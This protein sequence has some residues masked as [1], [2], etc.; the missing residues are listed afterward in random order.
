MR[1][2]A[3]GGV[4]TVIGPKHVSE[5]HQLRLTLRSALLAQRFRIRELANS[6]T[7]CSL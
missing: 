5:W 3:G 6:D 4:E 1:R 7:T 2:R